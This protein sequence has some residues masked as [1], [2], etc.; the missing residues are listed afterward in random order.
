MLIR[1][2]T[3]HTLK[4][5]RHRQLIPECDITAFDTPHG[6]MD[7]WMIHAGNHSEALTIH[8]GVVP[9]ILHQLTDLDILVVGVIEPQSHWILATHHDVI[10]M[11]SEGRNIHALIISHTELC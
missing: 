9:A 4:C 11:V 1:L 10:A 8:D 3:M 6:F 5:V 2:R 7:G